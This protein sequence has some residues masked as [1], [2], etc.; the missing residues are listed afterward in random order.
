MKE[1]K[2]AAGGRCCP[3]IFIIRDTKLMKHTPTNPFGICSQWSTLTFIPCLLSNISPSNLIKIKIM[4][5]QKKTKNLSSSS[6]GN[7]VSII[8]G[9]Y[10]YTLGS[11]VQNSV[12]MD[13]HRSTASASASA[14]SLSR[15]LCCMQVNF[16]EPELL[17]A[18]PE[19]KGMLFRVKEQ[20]F[21]FGIIMGKPKHIPTSCG[22]CQIRRLIAF[23]TLING[24]NDEI[25]L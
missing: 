1:T 15:R 23:L 16:L 25:N 13:R 9:I 17:T 19:Q 2:T 14:S 6:G 3:Y 4:K 21:V 5:K 22:R 10:N 7:V 8:I 24:I 20:I 11:Y 12:T 18:L